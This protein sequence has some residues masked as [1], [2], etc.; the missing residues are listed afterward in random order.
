MNIIIRDIPQ[1]TTNRIKA[2]AARRNLSQQ[3]LLSDL[4]NKTFGEPPMVFGYIKLD[5]QGDLDP[6]EICP[7]CDQV[8]QSWWVQILS[9]N[10]LRLMCDICAT[11]E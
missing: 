1:A 4:L 8:A 5:R 2:E 10:E 6:G 11:S 9:T 3:E 7:N